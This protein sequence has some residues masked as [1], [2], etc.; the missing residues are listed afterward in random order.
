VELKSGKLRFLPLMRESIEIPTEKNP[1]SAT[2]AD[3]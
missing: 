1:E 3:I 2:K